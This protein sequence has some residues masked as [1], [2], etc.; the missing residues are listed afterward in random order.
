LVCVNDGAHVTTL[1]PARG[2]YS[3]HAATSPAASLEANKMLNL[4]L[5]GSAIDILLQSDVAGAVSKQASDLRDH[6]QETLDGKPAHHFELQ[7]AGA[8]VQLWFAAEGPPLLLQ[9]TRTTCVPTSE[10]D[11]YEQTC[12]AKF[13]WKLGARPAADAFVLALPKD[14]R[15]VD[16]IYAAL[17]GN[18]AAAQIGRPLPDLTLSKLDG[19]EVKLAAYSTKKATVL[20]LWAT[21]CA[22]SIDEMPAVTEL[23]KAYKDRGA[24]FYAINVG[25]PPGQVRRFTAKSPLAS[26]VLLDPRSQTSAALHVT[27]LPAVVVVSPDNTVR[28]ILHGP[29]KT[30]QGELAGHLEALLGSSA[31]TA[32]RPGETGGRQK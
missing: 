16:E 26:T 8:N 17:A 11:F 10:S 1:F 3:R 31:K 28:A 6:G 32:R 5:Q 22:A 12:T 4:S 13:R 30:L 29:T 20:I 15:Q 14:A 9:F 24:A 2:L 7:W 18:E 27:E 21:W 25:E 23:V 19:S